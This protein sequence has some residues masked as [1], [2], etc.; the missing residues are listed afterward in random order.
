MLLTLNVLKLIPT[1]M[2]LDVYIDESS[3]TQARYL[4]LGGVVIPS[5]HVVA[6]SER[7]AEVRLPELPHGEMKWGKVSA[8]K[9]A[10]YTRVVD[11]FFD[12]NA[13]ASAHFHSLVVD[14]TKL[15]HSAFNGG[16]ADVGFNKEI[17]QLA[18]KCARIY[19]KPNFHVYLDH[20]DT[21]NTSDELRS[22]LN[23]GRR[24]LGDSR[25]WPF[26]R[27]HFRDSKT[28]HLLWITDLMIGA[29]AYH[30][31]GHRFQAGASAPRCTLSDYVLAKAGIGDPKVDTAKSGKFTIWHRQLR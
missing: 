26:R 25:D 28:T 14:T 21:K 15:N 19:P 29:I 7:I 23:F 9:L 12:H 6:A 18:T 2:T 30:L 22:I 13:F 5:E 11:C 27:C 20:R 31:N 4:L 16:S 3:Q 17:Y 24:K 8:A 10:A 1:G